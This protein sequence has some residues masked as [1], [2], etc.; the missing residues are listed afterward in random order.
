MNQY[1]NKPLMLHEASVPTF[2]NP[3]GHSD[4]QAGDRATIRVYGPLYHHSNFGLTYDMI[5]QQLNTALACGCSHI[6]L[7]FDSPG[8]T[9]SG[10]FSLA[11]KIYKSRQRARLTAIV[12]E[13]CYSA[14]YLLASACHDILIPATG[15]CGSIGVISLHCSEA[16]LNDR[17]GLDYTIVSAGR[18]K[19]DGNPFEPLADS[20]RTAIQNDVNTFYGLFCQTVARYRNMSASAIRST[21]A[22]TFIGQDAVSAGLADRIGTVGGVEATGDGHMDLASMLKADAQRRADLYHS[23]GRS[24]IPTKSDNPLIQDA[25]KR[26]Q[27]HDKL[28]RKNA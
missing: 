14:A 1:L 13:S 23:N 27:A 11:E 8:G 7:E 20:A 15:G 19:A 3:D 26:R 5:E 9:V 2:L 17:I 21:E 22:G 6:T 24:K 12:N 28:F 4:N 10:A 25:I 18:R 16:G